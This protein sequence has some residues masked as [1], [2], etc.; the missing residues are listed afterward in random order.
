MKFEEAQRESEKIVEKV[1]E[2]FTN[3]SFSI[4]SLIECFVNSSDQVR[5]MA[6]G[7]LSFS[8]KGENEIGNKLFKGQP[9]QEIIIF[10]DYLIS[11][12]YFNEDRSSFTLERFVSLVPSE[13]KVS[14]LLYYFNKSSDIESDA[15]LLLAQTEEGAKSLV[16]II[17]DDSKKKFHL[18]AML[19]VCKIL[20]PSI[21]D[22]LELGYFYHKNDKAPNYIISAVKKF[23]S[24]PDE[25]IRRIAIETLFFSNL[26]S[27]DDVEKALKST[28]ERSVVLGLKAFSY[29][30]LNIKESKHLLPLVVE[31]LE[32]KTIKVSD[33]AKE[34]I[35]YFASKLSDV[36]ADNIIELLVARST[37]RPQEFFNVGIVSN[38]L[39]ETFKFNPRLQGQVLYK[40]KDLAINNI[41]NVRVR[42]VLTGISLNKR[43]YLAL[44]NESGEVDTK[45]VSSINGIVS[46]N[47]RNS[48]IVSEIS[49][50][51]PSDIQKNAAIQISLLNSYY[52]NGLA[53]ARNSFNWAIGITAFCIIS[54]V[55]IILIY[56]QYEDKT[57]VWASTIAT[58]ITELI[59]GVLLVIYRQSLSQLNNY[60][61]Q[62][63]K[64][65]NYLLA[66]SFIE[67]LSGEDK[68][69][70][71]VDLIRSISG[72]QG[73]IPDSV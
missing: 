51:D 26:L 72:Y 32:G 2:L 3:N 7:S 29:L 25:A 49:E 54:F 22:V 28:S 70:A 57:I 48:Q 50:T 60:N 12:K 64:I 38:S 36:V 14:L 39:R 69:N 41:G 33:T 42:A 56:G 66:N 8:Y 52:E 27:I 35:E 21:G 19:S 71:R 17:Y 13:L 15:G 67:S 1:K 73:K 31:H 46:G 5:A 30:R 68:S 4:Q 43:E 44:V 6:L 61:Q 45:V 18:L 59:A 40:L 24:F 63:A 9:L 11:I 20:L 10:F 34:A 16:D 62:M 23:V 37:N 47:Q 55:I 58:C 53:Q 65:Q